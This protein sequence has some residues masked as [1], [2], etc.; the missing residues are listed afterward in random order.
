MFYNNLRYSELLYLPELSLS[1]YIFILLLFFTV[2][3]RF[4]TVDILNKLCALVSIISLMQTLY[5]LNIYSKINIRGS[6]FYF[7]YELN[8]LIILLKNIIIIISI[9]C[10]LFAINYSLYEKLIR[11][12]YY[13]LVLFSCL[14][15]ILLI[16][17]FDLMSIYFGIEI[18]SLCFYILASLKVHTNYSIEAGVKYFTQG[19]VASGFFLLGSSIVYFAT[20]TTNLYSMYLML[21]KI[22][23][24]N[25]MINFINVFSFGLSLIIISLLMKLAI[26]P[27]HM[28]AP[29]VYE[30][31]PTP[32]TFIFAI[33]PKIGLII[34][35]IHINIICFEN[36]LYYH[37]F[38][39]FIC[40][41]ISIFIGIFAGLYQTKIKR[42]FAFAGIAH[43]GYIV[44]IIVMPNV[45]SLEILLFY[46]F[47][48][49]FISI[50]IFLIILVIRKNNNNSKI[51]FIDELLII[52]DSNKQ[53][54][55]FF[56]LVL[57]SVIG[58]PPLIGFFSKYFLFYL[59]INE[60]LFFFSILLIS[61]NVI[62]GFYYLRLIKKIFFIEKNNNIK[63]FLKKLSHVD[64]LFFSFL[65]FI[66]VFACLYLEEIFYIIF[67]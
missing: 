51:K 29:D 9:I 47:I 38:I 2:L 57:L 39:I 5:F 34:T 32:V 56:S 27:F 11:W 58:I 40:G 44:L 24:D 16:S 35:L 66:N 10:I 14:G 67:N 19:A 36:S 46:L 30:G 15:N 52:S 26:A 43:M 55:I 17:S 6:F 48:Y 45:M 20:G 1:I 65:L 23:I 22:F 63:G 41:I 61:L 28:W 49:L 3:E 42:W 33:L 50:S 12:E 7:Q 31:V 64:S 21:N 13:I 62:S 18:Q 37:S 8:D 53:L 54:A 60:N 4:Y 25:S 59:F